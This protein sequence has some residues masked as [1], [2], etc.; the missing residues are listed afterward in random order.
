MSAKAKQILKAA[1]ELFA[2]GRYHEV[3]LDEICHRAGV[4]KGTVYRYFE[5]KEDL[6][7]QVILSGLDE[8]VASVKQVGA[9]EEDPGEGLR[10]LVAAIAD[11]FTRRGSLF[12]LM[13]SEQL[14]GSRRKKKIWKQWRKKDEE[15]L[16]VAAGFIV[17]GMEEGRY[18]TLL[19]PQAAARLLLG[20]VRTG[21]RNREE[22]P[23]GK[24]WHQV[25]V[26]LFEKGLLVRHPQQET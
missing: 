11:F 14:R 13:W 9:E 2:A 26:E 20:L 12:G 10:R 6:F 17:C 7:W 5:D 3:T 21:L 25:I 22:M 19:S 16:S 15:V 23:G 4:G 24:D 8:L 1:E 18:A